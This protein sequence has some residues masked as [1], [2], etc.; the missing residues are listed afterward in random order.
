MSTTHVNNDSN[1]QNIKW[2]YLRENKD[3]FFTEGVNTDLATYL[4]AIFPN[5]TFEYNKAV[6]KQ[7]QLDRGSTSH[8]LY[9]PDARCE[10]LNLIVEFDGVPHYTSNSQVL[11]D[12]N[13]DIYFSELGYEVIRIPYWLQLSQLNIYHLFG[14]DVDNN[15]CE[16]RYSF[17]D[18]DSHGLETCP[19]AMCEA[20]RLRFV[21]EFGM[22]PAETQQI[23]WDDILK[24]MQESQAPSMYILPGYIADM[25]SAKTKYTE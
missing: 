4:E 5:N 11:S 21:A 1:V 14:V 23:L 18:T 12:M 8:R 24:C 6:P 16:L 25:M 22:L 19:G 15:M 13:R 2:G 17:Y 3:K 7:I 9:R 10:E 20:G